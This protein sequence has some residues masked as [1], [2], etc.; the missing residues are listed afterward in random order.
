[1]PTKPFTTRERWNT[2]TGPEASNG[3]CWKCHKLMNDPGSSLESFDQTGRYRQTEPAYNDDN[4]VLNIDASGVLRDNSGE[5]VLTSFNNAREMAR[6]LSNSH[7]VRDCFTERLYRYNSGFKVDASTRPDVWEVQ[8][9]F[10]DHG[11]IKL[12][13]K[14]L[15]GMESFLYR[16]DYVF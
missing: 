4:K 9:Q 15:L 16:V 7:T 10:P 2:I 1:M 5:S 8:L 3:Q 12:L 13:S 11:N 14:A 6:Y